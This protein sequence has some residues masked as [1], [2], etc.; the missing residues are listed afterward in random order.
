MPYIHQLLRF[1]PLLKSCITSIC[2]K[3]LAIRDS[4]SLFARASLGGCFSFS[5]VINKIVLDAR[6]QCRLSSLIQTKGLSWHRHFTIA[7]IPHAI[8]EESWQEEGDMGK[9]T[10]A[11]IDEGDASFRYSE[12]STDSVDALVSF[13]SSPLPD[14]LPLQL[15]LK[16]M[17]HCQQFGITSADIWNTLFSHL[18]RQRS[19]LSPSEAT[20]VVQRLAYQHKFQPVPEAF[21]RDLLQGITRNIRQHSDESLIRILYACAKGGF[22]SHKFVDFFIAQVLERLPSLKSWQLLRVL[23]AMAYASLVDR[24]VLH[25]LVYQILVGFGQLNASEIGVF[26]PLFYHL[27]GQ[28]PPL[29]LVTK[30]NSS[31]GRR[32]HSWKQPESLL[33]ALYVMILFDLL[34]QNKISLAIRRLKLL[35]LPL[36]YP[37]QRELQDEEIYHQYTAVKTINT[38][39]LKAKFIE[40]CLRYDTPQIYATLPEDVQT[41]LL[42]IKNLSFQPI[43]A[44]E[45]TE[46]QF[47]FAELSSIISKLKFALHPLLCGPFLLELANPISK[48]I[49]EWDENWLLYPPYRRFMQREYI[50]RKHRFLTLEGWKIVKL[51]LKYFSSLK[52]E[53]AKEAWITSCLEK[54]GIYRFSS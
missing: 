15:V 45:G 54:E 18:S 51:P 7:A 17:H 49:I 52:E 30:L 26:I 29:S 44:H 42:H 12:A 2:W 22:A 35:S 31:I 41:Y 28:P 19:T 33:E 8:H 4:A 1:K 50:L 37:F 43:G 25:T 40:M 16:C 46:L 38:N 11:E 13:L 24:E 14:G 48:H 39:L 34:Q 21:V 32:M 3:H 5:Y 23:T 9:E 6:Y 53:A 20:K 27:Q 10:K 36:E 47:V